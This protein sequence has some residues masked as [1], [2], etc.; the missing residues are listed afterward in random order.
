MTPHI[1]LA[2]R[3]NQRSSNNQRVPKQLPR[4]QVFSIRLELLGLDPL[5]IWFTQRLQFEPW[6]QP[7]VFAAVG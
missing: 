4:F 3:L 5:D 7:S 1:A 6:M 2:F